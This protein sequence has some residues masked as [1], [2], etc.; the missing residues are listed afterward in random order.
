MHSMYTFVPGGS[1][2]A[3]A[4]G[5]SLSP[6]KIAHVGQARV[7]VTAEVALEDSPVGRAVEEGAPGLELLDPV[8]R[9]SSR[10]AAPSATRFQ[11][12]A[13]LHRVAEVDVLGSS[14]PGLDVP[15]RGRH[16]ALRHDRVRLAEQRLADETDARP[17]ALAS[18]AA[19]TWLVR[20][21]R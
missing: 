7:L 10:G 20:L 11:V 18:M 14:S 13:A 21:P 9:A 1:R 16:A 5:S 4:C 8:G 19:M 2:A 15:E 17:S 12:A 3:A 6:C